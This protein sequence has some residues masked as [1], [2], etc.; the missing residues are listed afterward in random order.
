MHKYS[1][2][3]GLDVPRK[4]GYAFVCGSQ[5]MPSVSRNVAAMLSDVEVDGAYKIHSSFAHGELFA[6]RPGFEASRN[7]RLI[8]PVIKAET[9]RGAIES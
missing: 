9:L 5:R 4:D 7:G 1:R 8:R 3:L 2:K 6:L